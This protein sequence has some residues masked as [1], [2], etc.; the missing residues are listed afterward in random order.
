[1]QGLWAQPEKV[2]PPQ[3]AGGAQSRAGCAESG[4]GACSGLTT[5]LGPLE[6]TGVFASCLSRQQSKGL[7]DQMLNLDCIQAANN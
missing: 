2:L 5:P 3:N 6:A 4:A 1:M 7:T